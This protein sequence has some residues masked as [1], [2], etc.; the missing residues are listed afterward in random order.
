MSLPNVNAA[1]GLLVIPVNV[2]NT[3]GQAIIS[4]DLNVDFDPAIVQPAA[5]PF[6]Q[7]G[8]LSSAMAITPNSNYPGH[9]VISAFQGASLTGSGTLIN[10][11]FN[12]VGSPG[13]STTLVFADFT[14]PSSIFHPGFVFNEGEPAAS[15]TNGS[16]NIPTGSLPVVSGVVTYGNAIG[17]P[18]VRSVPNVLIRS[19]I[20][21]PPVSS[22]T[23]LLGAFTL[24]G[25]GSGSYTVAPSRDDDTSGSISAFDAA[26]VGRHSLGLIRLAG[27]ALAAADVSG[28]GVV[29]SYDAG[30]IS[31]FVNASP[32]Q[33]GMTS[34]WT[35]IP[36]SRNYPSIT[37]TVTGENYSAMLM[38][39]VSGNWGSPG[40][41]PVDGLK[42]AEDSGSEMESA[43]VELPNLSSAAGKEIVVPVNVRGAANK[44]VIS[45]EFNLRYDPTVIQP[46][47]L[48]VEMKGTV[49]RGYTAS[50]NAA[51]PGI[52]RVVI[53]GTTPIE[54]SND[55]NLVLLNLRF[56]AVGD[57]GLVSP[58]IW[59]RI[60]FN[61][62]EPRVAA[63]DGQIELF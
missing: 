47:V 53:Y 51:E 18:A 38:G 10:L 61:E 33:H 19:T 30:L 63:A 50:T 49:S 14:D 2:G 41:R 39:D 36:A 9:L 60:M 43:I 20:G 23:D 54:G 24:T 1:P 48:P 34:K 46:L 28:N 7:A 11:R 57:A 22:T 59:E 32:F 12:V 42:T 21:S 31:G 8:T 13:Q 17:P 58:L 37:S 4:Y 52:L 44:G 27:G 3:T 35:F 6:D 56:M 62:G 40:T 5:T 25:F 16:V 45:Y 55:E 26:L 15:T 29:N